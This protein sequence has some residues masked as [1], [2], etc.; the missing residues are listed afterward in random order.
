MSRSSSQNRSS[1]PGH[2]PCVGL[3]SLKCA[4]FW[5]CI[6]QGPKNVPPLVEGKQQ[7]HQHWLYLFTNTT[8]LLAWKRLAGSSGAP[9]R[10]GSEID[11]RRSAWRR[12]WRGVAAPPKTGFLL[13]KS[14]FSHISSSRTPAKN[15]HKHNAN[16]WKQK[17]STE[18]FFTLKV[19]F[20]NSFKS[21]ATS[22]GVI[23]VCFFSRVIS[24]NGLKLKFS[25]RGL[26]TSAVAA[27]ANLVVFWV[28]QVI[29]TQLLVS[30]HRTLTGRG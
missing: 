10:G 6:N 29:N 14:R 22:F 24:Q 19:W 18:E 2:I 4:L 1:W 26:Q 13:L 23:F 16:G 17:I 27:A 21:A 9:Q 12:T 3:D 28:N 20:C 30:P 25:G 11:L 7:N 5:A 8:A 15:P